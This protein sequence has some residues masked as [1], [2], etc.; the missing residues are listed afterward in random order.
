MAK[1]VTK[2]PK[3][4]VIIVY[5]VYNDILSKQRGAST[6]YQPPFQATYLKLN[7]DDKGIIKY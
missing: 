4:I 3:V 6:T 5:L 2:L 7:E 1:S